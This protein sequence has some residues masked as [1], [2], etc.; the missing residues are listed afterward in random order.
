MSF[1]KL[2]GLGATGVSL[3]LLMLYAGV[4]YISLPTA[5]GGMDRIL[6]GVVVISLAVVVALLIAAH[7]VLAKQLLESAK[8]G[9]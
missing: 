6:F 8:R 7:L 1:P 9:S 5:T 4:V 3:G 2:A